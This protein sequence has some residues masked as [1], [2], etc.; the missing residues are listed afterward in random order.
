MEN[1]EEDL[2]E[3]LLR[4]EGEEGNFLEPKLIVKDI[5]QN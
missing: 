3:G 2:L 5:L 4:E 1:A